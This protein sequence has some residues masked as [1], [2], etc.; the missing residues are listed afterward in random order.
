MPPLPPPNPYI[1][2]AALG[3]ERGFFGR[4]D[5]LREVERTLRR[6]ADNAIVLYGQRRIGKTSILLQLQ[7]RLPS[8]PF[9]PIYFDLMDKAR[10]SL[11]QVL[12][13]LALTTAIE[14]GMSIPAK[15][16]FENTPSV[17]DTIFLP[18]LYQILENKRQLVYLLDEFD[19]F[20]IGDKQD[21][22]ETAAAQAF[23]PY[24]RQLM[25]TQTRLKFVV[26]VGRRMEELSI[27]FLSTFK[28]AYAHA[29]PVL[30]PEA[31]R[32]L[33]L[34]AEREGFL[35]YEATAI[36]HILTLTR[37]HPYLTQLTCQRLFDYAF[38]QSPDDTPTI[39]V[40]DIEAIVPTVLEAGKN[41]FQ[42]IWDGLPP[43]E[44]IIFSAIAGQTVAGAVFSEDDISLVLQEAGIR[45][46]VKELNLAPQTL[47]NW[48]MLE[49]VNGGYRFFIEL[50]RRWVAEY[51]PLDRVKDELDRVNPLADT[52]YQA[53]QG[54]YRQGKKKQARAQVRQ[55]LDLNP[56]HLKAHL[57]LGTI[58]REA[59][60]L[61]EAI[62]EFEAAYQ[63]DEQEGRFELLRTLLQQAEALEKTGNEA[64][65]LS[66]YNR[67]L[68]ISPHEQTAQAH[69]ANIWEKRGNQALA[70]DDLTAAIEAYRQAG[71]KDKLLQAETRQ[72]KLELERLTR[73]VHV[74]E[75]QQAWV[76]AIDLYRR[77]IE[78]DPDNKQW[79]EA[80]ARVE[81][82]LWLAEQY[83][84]AID[85][86]KHKDWTKARKVLLMIVAKRSDYR[87]AAE[88]L[89]LVRRQGRGKFDPKYQRQYILIGS[90]ILAIPILALMGLWSYGQPPIKPTVT[91]SG[92]TLD[93]QA[94]IAEIETATR[95]AAIGITDTTVG[96]KVTATETTQAVATIPGIGQDELDL[97]EITATETTQAIAATKA[98]AIESVL[99]PITAEVDR[100][101]LSTNEQLI[102]SIKVT[103]DFLDIPSP[104]LSQLTDFIIVN[105]STSTQVSIINGE[106]TTQGVFVYSLEPLRE[107]GLVIGPISVNIDG[108]I[109]Q[110]D[111]I[112][113][114]V[115]SGASSAPIVPTSELPETFQGQDFFVEAEID[116]PTPY[117][118]QQIIYTFR[119]YKA[120]W[121]PLIEQPD[122][123]PP[124]FTNF[125]G[126]AILSQPIY[127]NITARGKEYIVA[128]IR[129]ALFPAN[130]GQVTIDPARIVIPKINFPYDLVLETEPVR[131]EVQSLPDGAPADFNRAVGQFEISARLSRNQGLVGEPI[132][133]F[134]EIKGPGNIENF[135][136]PLPQ[137]P[138]WRFFNITPST[139]TEI[140]GQIL[141][142]TYHIERLMVPDQPGDYTLPS[143]NFSYFDPKDVAYH[144]ISTNPIPITIQPKQ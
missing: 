23:F 102:L 104:D 61:T 66:L 76:K 12:Y 110:T 59:N 134:L 123:Q 16:D 79:Q 71:T 125:R 2:G 13:E 113:I 133:L 143:I 50:L 63:L 75:Q 49:R 129:T 94:A 91:Q 57:L 108:Q 17:F 32:F 36:N 48:Q 41:A 112:D 105:S 67:V 142:S 38:D 9:V 126:Q 74:Y 6:P 83:A 5:I 137:L 39:T 128:E 139:T 81:D 132:S 101:I 21:A 88:K 29:V 93:I 114:R 35:R 103:S 116:N 58:L 96:A 87:D 121:V 37:G 117:P 118:G 51:R 14:V 53:A 27:S 24:L 92:A 90:I 120:M 47:V 115:I 46:L 64:D 99:S 44:R 97:G 69:R 106:L 56:N 11:G 22:P 26:V 100:T 82:E 62:E 72:R 119:F 31:A 30:K 131:I 20:D 43:A 95:A 8:P 33:I 28:A 78:L 138:N 42:W 144:T 70:R 60:H 135:I 140:R 111:P 80:L 19:V 3:G 52:L 68:T 141:Y 65:A 107:G 73:E 109:Y 86:I 1:A 4:E 130:L 84:T 40:E 55:A 124:S 85:Y 122:Y 136:P 89:V 15:G 77:L 34:Q 45:I 10:L 54:F 18:Q 7:R 98:V 127:N 25:M